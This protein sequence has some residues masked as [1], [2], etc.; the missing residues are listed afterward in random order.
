MSTEIVLS[1]TAQT[2]IVPAVFAGPAAAERRFWEFFTTQI[3]N[4][5]TRKAYFNAVRT[6][7]G[8]VPVPEDRRAGPGRADAHR[9][10]PEGAGEGAFCADDQAIPGG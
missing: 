8:L 7:F 1:P 3:S 9:R 6:F 5:N 10:V 4:D 2:L